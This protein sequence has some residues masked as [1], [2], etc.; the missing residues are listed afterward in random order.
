LIILRE[1][2]VI[3]NKPS[4]GFFKTLTGLVKILPNF[5]IIGSA[6]GGTT[7][8]FYYLI[9]HPHV[10]AGSGKELWFFDTNFKRG[11][12]WY[13]SNFPTIF[14]KLYSKIFEKK[15]IITGEASPN[16][17]F[18]PMAAKRAYSIIPHA[19]IIILLR[20]PIE[21]AY[22]SWAMHMRRGSEALSFE[23]AIKQE[24]KR[25]AG[26]EEKIFENE[27][28]DSF[29]LMHFSYLKRGIYVDQIKKWMEFFPRNQFLIL[30][31]EDL[32]LHTKKTLSQV[33]KFLEIPDHEVN[34]KKENV[35]KYV[36]INP[37]T[38]KKLSEFFKP[39]NER[40]YKFLNMNFDWK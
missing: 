26:E 25:I 18:H 16:Y 1:E 2:K 13:R 10:L 31:T 20:N 7:S 37:E 3:W 36:E 24:N 40:L 4:Y 30:K 6:K 22:S 5:L 23:E 39:H 12:I 34:L 11:L 29:K 17:I 35:G 21:R 19:K 32:D 28:Y 33:F 8:L 15:N 27:Y 9:Q 14:H 38:R